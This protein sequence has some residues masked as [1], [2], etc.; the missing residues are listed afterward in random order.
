M[1]FHHREPAWKLVEQARRRREEITQ[2]LGGIAQQRAVH[3]RSRAELVARYGH[4]LRELVETLVPSLDLQ[5]LAWA[6]WATGYAPLGQKDALARME[7]EREDLTA[8]IAQIEADPRFQ[9]R[10]LLR[11]PRVGTLVQQLD[12]LLHYRAPLADIVERCEH[13]RLQRLLH[14]GYGLPEYPVRFWHT[15]Y[16]ADWKAGD[17]ILDRF[18]DKQSFTEVRAAYLE[19]RDALT[20]HD[21]NIREIQAQIAAGEALEAEHRERRRALDTLEARWL[22]FA[23]DA[24]ARH[25]SEIDLSA[26]G[27]RLAK[28]PHVEILAKRVVGLSQQIVYLDRLAQKHLDE[29]ESALRGAL[30]K[31]ERTIA[32][33]SRPKYHGA[34]VEGAAVERL[35]HGFSDRYQRIGQRFEKQYNRVYVFH[36]YDRG[37]LATDFLWW[38]LMTDGRIDGNFIPEVRSFHERNPGYHYERWRDADDDHDDAAAAAAALGQDSSFGGLGISTDIS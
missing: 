4:A 1:S 26:L 6:A 21:A 9:N 27:E 30:G 33:Y 12:E 19:A 13:P 5:A 18:P 29:P 24:L 31:I 28:A 32:K 35:S 2:I 22:A 16:Y 25:L 7:R 17:E 11:A 8:R 20:V 23:R 37:S 34:Q 3:Q 14:L 38:D 15:A 36:D 10:E